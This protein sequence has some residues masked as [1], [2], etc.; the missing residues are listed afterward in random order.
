V[1]IPASKTDQE[2]LSSFADIFRELAD[3]VIS[4]INSANVHRLKE[5]QNLDN[6]HFVISGGKDIYEVAVKSNTL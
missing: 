4:D 2:V 1:Y 3:I 6:K 5:K